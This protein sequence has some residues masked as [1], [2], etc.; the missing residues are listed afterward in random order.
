MIQQEEKWL[1][2][3]AE[4]SG[5]DLESL[6]KRRESGEPLQY[7]LGEWEFY[8]YPFKV[9][10]GVLIPRPETELLVDFAKCRMQNAECRNSV[11][12]DLCAGSGCVGIALAKEIGCRVIAIE[13]SPEAV[14]Y[15]KKNVELNQVGE[16]FMV[17]QKDIFGEMPGWT[18]FDCVLIN[19]PYLSKTDM[20]NLQTEVTHEPKTAL[21][22]GKDGLDFYRKFFNNWTRVLKQA[23]LFACEVGDGQAS[24]VS[25]M[26]T[27][28]GLAP[29]IQKDYAGIERVV[30]SIGE[31]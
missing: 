11:I 5:A 14:K 8:G 24:A 27:A 7:I 19:P 17:L 1:R 4:R 6:Q 3:Y 30:Y 22:G 28:I 29:Q 9:G 18:P 12:L 15:L 10:K 23:T 20:E 31:Y 16:Q 2:E 13:K 26:M 25:E 21:Y